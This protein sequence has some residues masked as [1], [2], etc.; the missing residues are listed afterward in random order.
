MIRRKNIVNN[1]LRYAP[2][3]PN[4]PIDSPVTELLPA[5]VY[6]RPKLEYSLLVRSERTKS[7]SR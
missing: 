6:K 4:N 1:I 5:T 3:M 7:I 2:S